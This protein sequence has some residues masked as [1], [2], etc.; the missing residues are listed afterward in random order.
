MLST[1][2]SSDKLDDYESAI[3]N[4][5][6]LNDKSI[7]ESNLLQAQEAA[8]SLLTE[9]LLTMNVRCLTTVNE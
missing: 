1:A 3:E 8:K 6:R 5:Q 2:V 4:A 7:T 9:D